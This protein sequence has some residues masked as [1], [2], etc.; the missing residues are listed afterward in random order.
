LKIH[1]AKSTPDMLFANKLLFGKQLFFW[2]GVF[3]TWRANFNRPD[4]PSTSYRKVVRQRREVS[5]FAIGSKTILLFLGIGILVWI[6]I[7]IA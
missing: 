6:A 4:A 3:G 2:G 7:E 1:P 5:S